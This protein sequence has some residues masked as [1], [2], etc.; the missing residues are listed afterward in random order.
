MPKN[1]TQ[2]DLLISCPCDIKDEIRA[3]EE[4]VSCFNIAYSTVLGL[5]IQA[6]HWSNSAY[7]ESGGNS[8]SLLN[9]QFI[10]DCDAAVAVFWTRFGSPTDNHESGTEEE[11]ELMIASGKQVFLYFSDV[12][13]PPSK[14][15][16]EQYE[17]VEAFKEKYKNKGVY[18]TFSNIDDFKQLLRAHLDQHFLSL[19]KV[20]E[21]SNAKKPEFILSFIDAETGDPIPDKFK[22]RWP[23]G[24][25]HRRELSER[26]IEEI[27]ADK[28]TIDDVKAY[29]EKL[30]SIEIVEEFNSQQKLYENAQNNCW[31]MQIK[32]SNSGKTVGRSVSIDIDL[33]D[34]ILV[35]HDYDIKDI[36][37]PRSIP[38][39][40]KNPVIDAYNEL[41]ESR[42]MNHYQ[43]FSKEF[44]WFE[45]HMN[46]ME[47]LSLTTSFTGFHLDTNGISG[48]LI[49]TL[50]SA[51]EY[52]YDLC[53]HSRLS[54][55]IASLVHSREY[56]SDTISLIFESRGCFAI[57]FEI[58][59]EEYEEPLIGKY[60]IIVE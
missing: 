36:S 39:M 34:G 42:M 1:I 22:Y 58:M 4:V 50:I 35:Y 48:R 23:A 55:D 25:L 17:R 60:E 9:K 10:Q 45:K 14:V 53:G 18:W 24:L 37:A 30:P 51:K 7:P 29:N 5:S 16:K 31:N 43:A 56:I 28:V 33:P 19:K 41:H 27:I 2:Y 49:D 21:I 20:A 11:I 26:D 15:E 13:I 47:E 44:G 38:E 32:I 3:I 52:N 46:M 57:D 6:K 59:C 12:P 40:P 54:M 8:Q